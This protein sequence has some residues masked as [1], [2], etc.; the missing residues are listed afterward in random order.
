M[1]NGCPTSPWL[2]AADTGFLGISSCSD[3]FDAHFCWA[4]LVDLIPDIGPADAHKPVTDLCPCCLAGGGQQAAAGAAAVIAARVAQRAADGCTDTCGT[5]YAEKLRTLDH[6]QACVA[7][8]EY[9]GKNC[10]CACPEYSVSA[11]HWCESTA[12]GGNGASTRRDGQV[13]S[14]TEWHFDVTARQQCKAAG[15]CHWEQGWSGGRCWSAVGTQTCSLGNVQAQLAAVANGTAANTGRG[16]CA[17][18]VSHQGSMAVS[19]TANGRLSRYYGQYDF[20]CDEFNDRPVWELRNG[21][22]V[23]AKLFFNYRLPGGTSGWVVW[24]MPEDSDGQPGNGMDGVV[25]HHLPGHLDQSQ[26]CANDRACAANSASL[27]RD[28]HCVKY[29]PCDMPWE[30]VWTAP[31]GGWHTMNVCP[32]W[33]TER[34]IPCTNLNRID[35]LDECISSPCQNGGT[36]QSS[37]HTATRAASALPPI[38]SAAYECD[39][40]EGWTG[41]NCDTY[42]WYAACRARE[43]TGTSYSGKTGD[44]LCSDK[45]SQAACDSAEQVG[46][47]WWE[48]TANPP[49]RSDVGGRIV[50]PQPTFV[51]TNGDPNKGRWWSFCDC[52]ESIGATQL[53]GSDPSAMRSWFSDG[54]C[55]SLLN[56]PVCG[57]DTDPAAPI[58]LDYVAPWGTQAP[59]AATHRESG[60]FNKVRRQLIPPLVPR[61]VFLS[62]EISLYGVCPQI[63]ATGLD[64]DCQARTTMCTDPTSPMSLQRKVANK[65]CQPDQGPFLNGGI[66]TAGQPTEITCSEVQ[67]ET[68]ITS[69]RCDGIVGPQIRD[70]HSG[71][72]VPAADRWHKY[73]PGSCRPCRDMPRWCSAECAV[74]FIEWHDQCSYDEANPELPAWIWPGFRTKCEAALKPHAIACQDDSGVRVGSVNLWHTCDG[75]C[76]C[77]RHCEDEFD[78][79][80]DCAQ[81]YIDE[82][83]LR[84]QFQCPPNSGFCICRIGTKIPREWLC[85]GTNDCSLGEDEGG[86]HTYLLEALNGQYNASFDQLL[87]FWSTTGKPHITT[88]ITPDNMACNQRLASEVFPIGRGEPSAVCDTT[89]AV[90]TPACAEEYLPWAEDCVRSSVPQRA[91]AAANAFGLCCIRAAQTHATYTCGDGYDDASGAV[92]DLEPCGGGA[93]TVS[94]LALANDVCDH[95]LDCDEYGADGGDCAAHAQIEVPFT[96]TGGVTADVLKDSLAAVV[97]FLSAEDVEVVSIV[98]TIVGEIQLRDASLSIYSLRTPAGLAQLKRGVAAWLPT[99]PRN[100]TVTGVTAIAPANGRRRRLASDRTKVMQG[101]TI[102]YKIST[103]KDVAPRF[104]SPIASELAMAIN[105]ARPRAINSTGVNIPPPTSIATVFHLRI[106]VSEREYALSVGQPDPA[107]GAPNTLAALTGTAPAKAAALQDALQRALTDPTNQ[108]ALAAGL[109]RSLADGVYGGHQTVPS[110]ARTGIAVSA[111]VSELKRTVLTRRTVAAPPPPSPSVTNEELA[112]AV[113]V[114]LVVLLLLILVACIVAVKC[115]SQRGGKTKVKIVDSST[116]QVIDSFEMEP[117][118]DDGLEEQMLQQMLQQHMHKLQQELA[119]KQAS[120]TRAAEETM[121]VLNDVMVDAIDSATGE[122]S[123]KAMLDALLGS[124]TAKDMPDDS[125]A[126]EAFTEMKSN[127]ML[128][129]V[130]KDDMSAGQLAELYQRDVDKVL[131]H[132]AAQR[133]AAQEKLASRRAAAA[134]KQERELVL[135]GAS[136]AVA[137]QLVSEQGGLD[138]VEAEETAQL[139]SEMDA[140]EAAALTKANAEVEGALAAAASDDAKATLREQYKQDVA[141]VSTI[142][143]CNRV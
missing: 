38:P 134:Q 85:D 24:A 72:A 58:S 21:G 41:T 53:F 133:A 141:K 130:E 127:L 90:C 29:H 51:T 23:V 83:I 129:T 65:C 5:C 59:G 25:A 84:P 135:A 50:Y 30:C 66:L 92:T 28:R 86:C 47:C 6:F 34:S 87:D 80:L 121:S 11:E 95:A 37:V 18:G 100:V 113:V 69:A 98:Q 63:E 132:R 117:D 42:D 45:T 96:I 15:C 76:D 119:T 13:A 35:D 19:G 136:P 140:L 110:W 7:C 99:R 14:G 52:M 20:N 82:Q 62:T 120:E 46:G 101:V 9:E 131:A 71:A 55:H 39:C 138:Q 67:A 70:K 112:A 123:E 10:L 104:F 103:G 32:Q 125:K 36:C 57:F 77:A 137:A 68:S 128:A 74:H 122:D 126:R 97:P 102:A 107:T 109:A 108:A 94:L 12:A 115:F 2:Y 54:F 73:C 27:C 4:D 142:H 61:F 111:S 3:L 49:C 105:R 8:I 26:P 17:N 22:Q 75:T 89:R 40:D 106:G 118:D 78:P 79:S 124:T 88:M 31:A 143:T 93:P 48:P 116:G 139:E 60:P 43:G 1:G 114:V 33:M 16:F 81:R 44:Q 64:Q 91:R 56:T